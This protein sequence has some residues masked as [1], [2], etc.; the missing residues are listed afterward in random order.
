MSK[1]I[2]PSLVTLKAEQTDHTSAS[3]CSSSSTTTPLVKVYTADN[4]HTLIWG[5]SPYE[6]YARSYILPMMKQST[7]VWIGNVETTMIVITV[8]GIPLPVTINDAQY[9][10]SYTCS[11]YTHYISY[12]REELEILPYRWLQKGLSG[13][14]SIIGLCLRKSS[15]NKVV[16]INNWLVSTNLYPALNGEQSIAVLEYV[17]QLYP[18]YAIMYRSLNETTEPLL[19]HSLQEYGC[20]SIPSRQIY[21]LDH[22][23]SDSIN[24]K[25]RWLIK[26]DRQLITKQGYTVVDHEHIQATD[27]ARIVEL[28]NMLYIQ[29]YSVCNPQFTAAFI[30]LAL[31]QQILTLYGLRKNG[32]LDGV[33]G[34]F[35]RKGI[36][37]TPLF[38]YDTSLPQNT[39]L[40]RMLSV[41]LIDISKQNGDLLHES[42]GVGQFKRNRGAIATLE[43]SA[44]YDRHLKWSTRCCWS[45]LEYILYWIGVPLIRK[46]KL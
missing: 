19:M 8:D 46:F 41:L 13:L 38:G 22:D 37:T 25:T 16:Q 31:E 45:L 4:I 28:Y 34:F 10:N 33:L 9:S 15:F 11:P 21:T 14:L 20:K 42:S 26:R 36:M 35:S 5:D 44:V 27:I 24:A 29:K 1:P 3:L 23:T 7:D 18:D 12:A 40:Y 43:V 30:Q 2:T 32:Q 6:Q 39:G 17:R